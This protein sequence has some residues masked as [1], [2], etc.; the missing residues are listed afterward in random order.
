MCGIFGYIGSKNNAADIVL[1]GLKLLEYRGYDSWGIAAKGESGKLKVENHDGNGFIVEKHVGKIGNVKL[2]SQF[3]TLHSQLAIGHTR[4]A[5][6]G[7]VSDKNAHPHLDC[8]KEIAVV[9][10]GI[11]ENFIDLRNDLLKKGHTF[12]SETDTEVFVHLVEENI[13]TSG[14]AT[15]VR[16][17]FGRISGLNAVVVAYAPS[18][19]IIA[20]K[21]GSP[22]VVGKAKDGLYIS[23]DISGVIKHTR[24][25]LFVKDNEMVILGKELQLISLKNGKKIEPSFETITWSI[26]EAEKGSYEHF[27]L[28][29]IY[30]QPKVIRNIAQ[31]YGDQVNQF[32]NIIHEAY[33][34]FFIAAGT[35]YHAALAGT[36]L[37]SKIAHKHINTA[38]ASEFNYLEDFLTDKTLVIALSQSGE[39]IDVIEPLNR[40]KRKGSYIAAVVN[41]LGSTIYRLAD[42]K[43]L[44]GAGPEKAV[45]STKAYIAKLAILFM[46]SYSMIEKRDKSKRLLLQVADEI[47]RLLMPENRD[48]IQ[49]IAKKL[50]NIEHLYTVGRGASYPSALEAALKIKEVSYIHTEGLAGGELKHGTIALITKGT[51]CLVFAPLDETYGAMLSNAMEIKSRGGVIIGIGPKKSDIFDYWIEV[52]DIGDATVIAQI[53]PAQLLAY[54][55]SAL[56]G[57]DPDKP[58]NLAKSVTV[59]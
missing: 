53:V 48:V 24:D 30:E 17:A 20:A 21:T 58:R 4:W 37:F 8:K 18:Q 42:Y 12:V 35:A 29:E 2:S 44:L 59:K 45:A 51:P 9:H 56:R 43:L 40:A 25:V 36:Y 52:K 19:E 14:F 28:K 39:T 38:V 57:N 31:N 54:F 7:G 47:E 6:H 50:Q 15:A 49:H 10:N 41:S 3:S 13:K 23:S 46:L 26:E 32:A 5:T 27:M 22:L 34:T 55:L 16:D 11:I 33:G 1:D